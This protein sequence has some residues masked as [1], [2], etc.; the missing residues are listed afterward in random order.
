[1]PQTEVSTESLESETH[2]GE[3]RQ[4][5]GAQVKNDQLTGPGGISSQGA[6][7]HKEVPLLQAHLKGAWGSLNQ[8]LDG[9]Q[10]WFM[11][12]SP[13]QPTTSDFLGLKPF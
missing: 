9:I 1:M 4:P 3:E 2:P 7:L 10:L 5:F 12:L 8:L 11:T 13:K 6:I